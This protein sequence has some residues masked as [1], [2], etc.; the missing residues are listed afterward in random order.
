MDSIARNALRLS[1]AGAGAAVLGA[2]FIGQASAA[3]LPAAPS[4]PEVPDTSLA[5]NVLPA[6]VGDD[7]TMDIGAPDATSTAASPGSLPAA[8]AL[9]SLDDLPPLE[10]PGAMDVEAP[11]AG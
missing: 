3:E 9:P 1:L 10:I 6:D 2:G 7:A 4:T 5:E 11:T 8:D